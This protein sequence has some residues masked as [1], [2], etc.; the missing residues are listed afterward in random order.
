MGRRR[1]DIAL[2]EPQTT[3]R[4]QAQAVLRAKHYLQQE[5]AKRT[6]RRANSSATRAGRRDRRLVKTGE[7]AYEDPWRDPVST[8]PD[9]P[10][11]ESFSLEVSESQFRSFQRRRRRKAIAAYW[12][13]LGPAPTC[14]PGDLVSAAIFHRRII[15]TIERGGWT[16]NEQTALAGLER[17]WRKRATGQDARFVLAG[18][19]PGR[20]HRNI[21]RRVR[22]LNHRE[23]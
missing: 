22:E 6:V 15:S 10:P 17:K 12:E 5:Q 19:R 8:H 1:H 20:L 4:E 21:E 18:N 14:L 13:R 11:D 7:P 16:H 2:V 3:A 23:G 9:A